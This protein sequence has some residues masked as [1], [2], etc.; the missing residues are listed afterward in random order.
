VLFR[1]TEELGRAPFTQE[2]LSAVL[3]AMSSSEAVDKQ[4]KSR[5]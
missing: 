5:R 3:V 2:T 4:P 1:G